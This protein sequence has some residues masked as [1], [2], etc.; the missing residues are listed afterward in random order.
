[1]LATP[2]DARRLRS[3]G[4]LH[5]QASATRPLPLYCA[6]GAAYIAI[7]ALVTE[8]LLSWVVGFGFLLICVWLLPAL[9]RGL[10]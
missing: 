2:A 6:A 8:I 3:P 1:M 9:V 4:D 7:G 10:R 5:R